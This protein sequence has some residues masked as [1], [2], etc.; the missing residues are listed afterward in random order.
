M[1]KIADTV[2]EWSCIVFG[3][4]CPRRRKLRVIKFGEILRSKDL[5]T[6]FASTQTSRLSTMKSGFFQTLKSIGPI[7]RG[8]EA[9]TL[10]LK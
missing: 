9:K 7:R 5:T 4:N 8:L 10:S 2:T 1:R 6:D 3:I